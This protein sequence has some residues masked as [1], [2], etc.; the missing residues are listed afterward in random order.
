[1]VANNFDFSVFWPSSGLAIAKG[2]YPK[3]YCKYIN[4][5]GIGFGIKVILM[6]FGARSVLSLRPGRRSINGK[7]FKQYVECAL[8]IVSVSFE[9]YPIV[10]NKHL[11]NESKKQAHKGMREAWGD[12]N[13]EILS[14][15]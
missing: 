12:R 14:L 4:L 10:L 8:L 11:A 15:F 1:M 5:Y 7:N 9:K 3:T 2:R 13:V 6:N